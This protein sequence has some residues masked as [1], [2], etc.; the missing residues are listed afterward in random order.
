VNPLNWSG[1][2]FLLAYVPYV[3]LLLM[4]AKVWR[5]TLNQ[6]SAE[7]LSA[8]LKLDPYQVAVL[9]RREGAVRAAVAALVHAG[10]LRLEHGVLEAVGKP[11]ASAVPFER[12]VHAAVAGPVGEVS[13]LQEAVEREVDGMEEG[14][15]RRGF[16]MKPEVAARC[17]QYP[18]VLYFGAALGLGLL[19]LMV[20]LSRGRP[21][22]FL[23]VLLVLGTLVGFMVLGSAPRRT[24]RG[25][26]AWA[27]LR[28]DNA[29]LR[30]TAKADGAWGTMSSASVALAVA[31]FGTGMLAASGMVDLRDYLV[32]PGSGGGVDVDVGGDSGG[33]SGG[34]GDGGGGCGGGCGGCGGGGD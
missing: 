9:D 12:T 11:P 18:M 15:R 20:G 28:E 1:E 13:Q 23:L 19:K 27:K 21:V 24:R 10:A 26:K 29:A 25:D 34:G 16:L 7:P 22:G 14:L 33:D 5:Y 4:V 32:P 3:L 31:L 8:E 6:P 17:R 2:E 30:T